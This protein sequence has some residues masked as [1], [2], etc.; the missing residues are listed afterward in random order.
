MPRALRLRLA[1]SGSGRLSTMRFITMVELMRWMP[2]KV[3]SFWS[4]SVV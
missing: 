2:G 3:A 1:I 4:R